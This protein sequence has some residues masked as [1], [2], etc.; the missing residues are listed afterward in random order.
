[1]KKATHLI[2]KTAALATFF[3]L[4]GVRTQAQDDDIDEE[5]IIDLGRSDESSFF[6]EEDMPFDQVINLRR[7]SGL[8]TNLVLLV[9][10]V[11]MVNH[12]TRRE[13]RKGCIFFTVVFF[14]ILYL[15]NRV[16]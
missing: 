13:N 6:E 7:F 3:L 1:M 14:I 10:I 15:I 11:T 12:F 4:P 5:P 16:I 8:I 9:I 2:G